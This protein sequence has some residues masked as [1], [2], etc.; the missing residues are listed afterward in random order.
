MKTMMIMACLV[1]LLDANISSAAESKEGER[2]AASAKVFQEVMDTPDNAIP[3][4]L[5]ERCECVAIVPSMK[6][7][8]FIFGGR[9]GKGVVSC[10]KDQGAGPWGPPAMITVKGGSFGLQIGGAAVDVVMLVM[11]RDGVNS[12]LKNKFTLG[13]DASVAGGPVG[14]A[15][16]AQTDAHMKAKML[17]YSRSRGVFAGLEL[18]GAVVTQDRKANQ[19][20]YGKP[21]GAKELLMQGDIA[22]PTQ[23]QSLIQTLTKHSPTRNRKPS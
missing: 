4:D 17:S 12:L 13:G 6:K 21:I 3:Q 15:A 16:T 23:A 14:R 9:Y 8:G 20:L 2:L 22:I 11:D 5:L 1:L 10:R 19:S 7:G 18:K